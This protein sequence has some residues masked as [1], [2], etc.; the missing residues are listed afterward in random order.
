MMIVKKHTLEKINS[1]VFDK[2]MN[3]QRKGKRKGGELY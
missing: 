1:S 2:K 3:E